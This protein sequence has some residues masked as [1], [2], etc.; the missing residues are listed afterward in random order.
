VTIAELETLSPDEVDERVK[1][2]LL[3][4]IDLLTPA[5]ATEGQRRAEF[6]TAL[7][8]RKLWPAIYR[9]NAR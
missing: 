2:F 9:E 5:G 4:P 1:T 8:D 7:R 3:R 6:V